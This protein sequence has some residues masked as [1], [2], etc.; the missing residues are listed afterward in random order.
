VKNFVVVCLGVLVVVFTAVP[1]YSKQFAEELSPFVLA[2]R[3]GE[4][5]KRSFHLFSTSIANYT[6]THNGMAEGF[7]AGRRKL[8]HVK[9]GAGTRISRLYYFE[10][11]GDLLLLYQAGDS[12]YLARLDQKTRKLRWTKSIASDFTPPIIKEGSVVFTDGVV[13]SLSGT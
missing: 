3:I 5:N 8:F 9:V 1:A 10:H 7:I 2:T 12:G 6:I 4:P 13:I 11:E